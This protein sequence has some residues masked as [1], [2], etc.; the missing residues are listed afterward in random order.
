MTLYYYIIDENTFITHDGYMQLGFYRMSIQ[1]FLEKAKVN[2]VETYWVP[3]VFTNRYKRL[4]YQVHLKEA[5]IG[6]KDK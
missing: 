6:T 1:E 3:D 5:S 4:P 2:Y